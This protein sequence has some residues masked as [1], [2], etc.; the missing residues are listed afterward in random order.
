MTI[1]SGEK[2]LSSSQESDFIAHNLPSIVFPS[3]RDPRLPSPLPSPL[4]SILGRWVRYLLYS[5]VRIDN[6]NDYLTRQYS[7]QFRPSK[8]EHL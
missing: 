5:V 4:P 6:I 2:C 1:V 8:K 3:V 7:S